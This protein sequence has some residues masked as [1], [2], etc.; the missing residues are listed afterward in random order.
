MIRHRDKEKEIDV[1]YYL[2]FDYTT[3]AI[4]LVYFANADVYNQDINRQTSQGGAESGFCL[5]QELRI[6][7][8]KIAQK[9][10]DLDF[11]SE[12]VRFYT[13]TKTYL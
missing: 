9:G 7:N 3:L 11:Y 5:W 2:Q 4:F 8:Q 10:D 6:L 13:N 12:M 1:V